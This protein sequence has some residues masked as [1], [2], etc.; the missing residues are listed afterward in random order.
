MSDEQLS[1]TLR[2]QGYDLINL[3]KMEK[4]GTIAHNQ[5]EAGGYLVGKRHSEGGIKAVNKSTGK[6]LEM[7]GGEVVITRDAVSDDEKR[8]FEGEM[9][10][11]REILSRIN[12]SG[13]GVAFD[14]GGEVQKMDVGGEISTYNSLVKS[15]QMFDPKFMP[16][17]IY[18]QIYDNTITPFYTQYVYCPPIKN[19][20]NQENQ[21]TKF[22]KGERVFFAGRGLPGIGTIVNARSK[23]TCEIESKGFYYTIDRKDIFLFPNIF[24]IL[25]KKFYYCNEDCNLPLNINNLVNS[26]NLVYVRYPSSDKYVKRYYDEVDADIQIQS[27]TF[28]YYINDNSSAII[29]LDA[30]FGD[31]KFRGLSFKEY[32]VALYDNLYTP[33]SIYLNA[34]I[35]RDYEEFEDTKYLVNN[36]DIAISVGKDPIKGDFNLTTQVTTFKDAME[37]LT[38]LKINDDDTILI[39]IFWENDKSLEYQFSGK[40]YNSPYYNNIT[41]PAKSGIQVLPLPVKIAYDTGWLIGAE[42]PQGDSLVDTNI[43]GDYSFYSFGFDHMEN[44]VYGVNKPILKPSSNFDYAPSQTSSLQPS[45][46]YSI[47]GNYNDSVRDEISTLYFILNNTPTYEFETRI[48]LI[49][50]IEKLN[51][52]VHV[53]DDIDF[54]NDNIIDEL[55]DAD[56][57]PNPNRPSRV[58]TQ[59]FFQPNGEPTKLTSFQIKMAQRNDFAAWFGVYNQAYTYNK[60]FPNEPIPCSKVVTEGGEPLV[61]YMGV[62]REFEAVRF[63]RFPIA[64]FAVNY[65]YA[66]W[67]AETKN[68]DGGW[69]LPFFLDIKN[70]L[71]LT[72]FGINKVPAKDFYDWLFLQ[73]GMTH[74]E[75]GFVGAWEDPNIPPMEVWMYI[76]NNRAFLQILKDSMIVD[77]I[78]FYEN[79]PANDPNSSNYKTEVWST[80]Y[81]NQSKLASPERGQ[82]VLSSVDSF[83]MKKGGKLL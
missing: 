59:G 82:Y 55:L 34:C 57:Y 2:M 81:P 67:F 75:L 44:I 42:R 10:T 35:L 31:I 30:S 61:V 46:T 79:N 48:S 38:P 5:G 54:V 64:Y 45:K 4:G 25:D 60:L 43:D 27:G 33:F 3:E 19:K 71:D 23:Q 15:F 11:N 8:E 20:Y 22:K 62:G 83:K 18:Q 70:P 53:V 50:E 26:N 28:D 12:Q 6:L 40:Y 49:Q 56:T 77:G 65:D 73:T 80:F 36:T 47:I 1:N 69:V 51:K 14:K 9:L 76:R 13:G 32:V 74:K 72:L 68:Q 7:E 37:W 39:K 66:V 16:M 29:E 78:H 63:N 41:Y 17:L 52:V 58:P 24:T 21:N